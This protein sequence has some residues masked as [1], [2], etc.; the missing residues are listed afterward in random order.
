MKRRAIAP[1]GSYGSWAEW[2]TDI[3]K[4][5]LFVIAD[6]SLVREG[7]ESRNLLLNSVLSS[8]EHRVVFKH[9]VSVIRSVAIDL[10][11]APL[12][13]GKVG[14]ELLA[15]VLQAARTDPNPRGLKQ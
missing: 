12:L 9:S 13:C 3:A 5:P 1:S 7:F 2:G 14:M 8:L 15:E 4:D 10:L 11:S 6:L